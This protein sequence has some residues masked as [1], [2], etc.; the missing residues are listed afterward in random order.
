MEGRDRTPDGGALMAGTAQDEWICIALLFSIT[1]HFPDTLVQL[2][3]SDGEVLLIEAA[4]ELPKWLEPDTSEN[5][6]F[7]AGGKLQVM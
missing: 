2:Y 7:V 5:R 1:K 6:V 4:L 3:D